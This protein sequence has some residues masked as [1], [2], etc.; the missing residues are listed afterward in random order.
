MSAIIRRLRLAVAAPILGSTLLFPATAFADSRPSPWASNITDYATSSLENPRALS[1][2]AVPL[3][4]PGEAQYLNAS[5]PMSP[6]SIVKVITTYA[7]LELLGP[8][9]TWDTDFL[10]TGRLE[11]ST[12]KGDLYLRYGGDP[13]FSIERLWTALNELKGMGVATIE[14]DLILDGSYFRLEGDQPR[15]EDNGDEP[16]R[17]FLVEPSG[18]LSNFNLQQFHLLADERGLRAWAQPALPQVDIDNRVALR[19]PGACPGRKR[20]DWQPEFH[21]DGRVT[22]TIEGQLPQGCRISNYLSLLPPARYSATLA[23]TLMAELGIRITGAD[24]FATTPETARKLV[25]STSP[26][27]V[28]MVRDINKWSSN[29]MARQLLLTIGA[30]RREETDRDDRATGIR[31]VTAWMEAKGIDTTGM[32]LDNGA[33]LTRD[34]RIT[35]QQVVLLLQNAWSSP[36]APDLMSSMPIIAMDGTMTKRLQNTGLKGEGRIKTGSLDH[37][38]S[39]A[40]FTRDSNNTTWAVV[41]MVNNDPAW[42]GQSVLDR[43]LYS[44]YFHP[45]GDGS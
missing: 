8:N 10:T 25:S 35:A 40:G 33:G 12:L 34:G 1:V 6:G 31:E 13:K 7:A 41:A 24:R 21:D 45:P 29:V 5:A 19:T 4:G 15:F 23:R 18:Y 42:N 3:N 2:A 43:V 22:L 44:L 9:Y 17:P 39:I 14:G 28:T 36:Y 16:Y 20:F 37:V 27:L 30:E 38:R 26:D 11:G 32:V